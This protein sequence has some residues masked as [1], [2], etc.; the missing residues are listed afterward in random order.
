M[1][2]WR[3]GSRGKDR[4]KQWGSVS[5]RNFGSSRVKSA[6]TDTWVLMGKKATWPT[7][8]WLSLQREMSFF[9]NTC[10]TEKGVRQSQVSQLPCWND[11]LL[12]SPNPAA[13]SL[14]SAANS[15]FWDKKFIVYQKGKRD[16]QAG[17]LP[18]WSVAAWHPCHNWDT[19]CQK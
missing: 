17:W 13:W 19:G 3:K 12:L 6:S 15:G 2:R 9:W 10:V 8:Q 7:I 1:D 14:P 5:S 11:F 18:R 16:E 4:V